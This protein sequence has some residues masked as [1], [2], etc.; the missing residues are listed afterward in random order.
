MDRRIGVEPVDRGQQLTLARLGRK[1]QQLAVH[2]RG[3]TRILLVSDVN[4]A[5]RVIAHEHNR[6]T[7][8]DPGFVPEPG[9]IASDP[10]ADLLGQGFPI[11]ERRGHCGFPENSRSGRDS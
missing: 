5:G 9:N 6:Q 7:G 2:P 8:H 11:E 3:L 10:F 1:P 4:L